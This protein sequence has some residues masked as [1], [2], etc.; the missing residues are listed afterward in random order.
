MHFTFCAGY[1]RQIN[2]RHLYWIGTSAVWDVGND[3]RCIWAACIRINMYDWIGIGYHHFSI[4]KIPFDLFYFLVIGIYSI[5]TVIL[6]P[7]LDILIVNVR[8]VIE[9][10][11][12]RTL[13]A[14]IPFIVCLSH[15]IT[16]DTTSVQG[17]IAFIIALG[18]HVHVIRE[19]IHRINGK[20]LFG[21]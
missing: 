12:I 21:R 2:N 1:I 19:R 17:V 7:T 20:G 13:R 8:F 5:G 11:R 3:S 18:Y 15:R 10:H 6:I 14:A 16:R 9:R 4:A